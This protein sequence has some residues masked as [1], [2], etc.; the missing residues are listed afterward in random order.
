LPTPAIL[1]RYHGPC[2]CRRWRG[3]ASKMSFLFLACFLKN[4]PKT[5]IKRQSLF[6]IY[7]SPSHFLW[8]RGL[9]NPQQ[10][11]FGLINPK[12]QLNREPTPTPPRRGIICK[13]SFV[14]FTAS[15]ALA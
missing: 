13:F 11:T 15:L 1:L 8:A 10:N 14:Y 12:E 5:G 9:G 3:L 7:E 4:R 6:G 2:L